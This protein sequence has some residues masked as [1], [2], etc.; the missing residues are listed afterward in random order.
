[1]MASL[2]IPLIFPQMN[3]FKIDMND[4]KFFFRKTQ[5][6]A[7]GFVQYMYFLCANVKKK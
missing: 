3:S 1:M 5:V 2:R 7:T 6:T 4:S